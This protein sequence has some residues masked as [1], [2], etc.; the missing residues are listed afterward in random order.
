MS[1]F[2][3]DPRVGLHLVAENLHVNADHE[4]LAPTLFRSQTLTIAHEACMR[5]AT[6]ERLA[7][8]QL[9][10]LWKL[11]IRLL[12]DAVLRKTAWKIAT[13]LGLPHT[14]DCE[15]FALTRLQGDAFVTMDP[16]L[17]EMAAR[18][19]PVAS[20]EDLL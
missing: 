17:K 10:R 6:D 4:L 16:D 3:I 1:K 13:D 2:V 9:D 18:V 14:Y 20:L 11:N 8:E 5:G 15:Y 12:G 19:V 7:L